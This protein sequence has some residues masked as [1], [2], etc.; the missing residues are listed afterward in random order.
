MS[1]QLLLE[2]HRAVVVGAGGALG[3]AICASYARLGATLVAGDLDP[4]AAERALIDLGPGHR[5]LVV[6]ATKHSSISAFADACWADGHVD[7]MVYAPGITFTSFV[8]DIDWVDHARLLSINLDGAFYCGQIFGRRFLQARRPAAMTFISS[9]AGKRGEAGASSYCA[10]KFGLLGFVE[11]FAL[12]MAPHDIRV[13]AICPG[14][15]DS[16]MLLQVARAYAAREQRS[17]EEVLRDF[18][19]QAGARRLVRPSE[20]GDVCAWLASPLATAIAGE[21]VNVDAATLS[22]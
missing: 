21:S 3:N 4:E 17:V 10:S 7:S 22:G 1:R 19:N 5:A 9:N 14:N 6:D 18:A 15:V 13:N 16:P 12:E 11:S 8:V 2:G 20:V